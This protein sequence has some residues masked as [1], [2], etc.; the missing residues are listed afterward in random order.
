MRVPL[1]VLQKEITGRALSLEQA[2]QYLPML[3]F[4]IESMESLSGDTLLEIE[5]TANRSDVLSIRGIARDLAA[6]LGTTLGPIPSSSVAEGSS[7]F[8]IRLESALC[9]FYAAALVDLGSSTYIPYD[10]TK[11]LELMGSS[12]KA[13]ACVDASNE[14]LYRY[15]QPTHAFDLD[16]LQGSIS[17]R[18]AKS[19]EA[20]VGLDGIS[21]TLTAHDLV[22]ADEAGPVALA[23]VLGGERAKVTSETRRILIESASF[24]AVSVRTTAHRFNLHTEASNRFGRGVD[25]S[26][27]TPIRNLLAQTIAQWTEGKVTA[28]WNVGVLPMAASAIPL[29]LSLLERIAGRSISATDAIAHLEH[30][31]ATV[32]LDGSSLVVTPPSWRHDLNLA[33]DLAEEILRLEGYD[34]IDSLL[35]SVEADPL[36]MPFEFTQ[37][38]QLSERLAHRGFFQTLTFGFH[39]PSDET[40]PESDQSGRRLSN[41]LGEEYSLMRSSLMPALKKSAI[42]NLRNGQAE[43]RLFEIAPVYQSHSEGPHSVLTL[44]LVWGGRAGGE[45]VLTPAQNITPLHLMGLARTLQLQDIKIVDLGEGLLGFEIP[46]PSKPPLTSPLIPHFVPFSRHPMVQRDLSLLVP[47][48]QIYGDVESALKTLLPQACRSLRCVEI[49]AGKGVAEGHEAWLL[50]F[51]FQADRSLTTEEVDGWMKLVVSHLQSMQ[52][53]LR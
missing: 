6:K 21:R 27:V 32:I 7:A 22:I 48:G 28:A 20:F 52:I 41:P 42:Q 36:P 2:R 43:V 16:T 38:I 8:P 14:L 26:L 15:G 1:S 5:T 12:S 3:G 47:K 33:E 40:T 18:L 4:P 13:L 50:R 19:G 25:S 49:Y 29:P 31:G 53:T 51:Q 11:F 34:R 17:V 39:G 24:D 44:A 37:R 9:S 23:G 46:L 35:P 30:L 45:D 10:T